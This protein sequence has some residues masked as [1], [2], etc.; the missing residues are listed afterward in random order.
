MPRRNPVYPYRRSAD[1]DSGA[2]QH[3]AV[4][5]V[6]AGPS[7]LTAA[8]E[9]AM[10]GLDVVLLDDNDTVSTGSRAICFAK[11][12]LEI[13]DRL[14]CAAPMLAKGVEWRV[15]KVF[16]RDDQVYQFNLMPDGGHK[17][18]AF[19]NL[20]QYYV[21]EVLIER[22][23][24]LRVDLRWRNRVV[25]VNPRDDRVAVDV[26]TPDGRYRMTCD[27]LLA[28][29][30][31]SSTVGDAIGADAVGQQFDDRFLIADITM[32]AEFPTE[33][34]FWFDPPFHRGQSV[35]LHKQPDG[36]WRV[37]FQLGA[38]ADPDEAVKIENIAPRIDAMLGANVQWDLEWA[39]AYTFRCRKLD[40]F[41]HGRV[42]FV[43]D[44]AHQVSPFGARGANGAVQGI[45]NL[46][47]K[48]VRV[49]RGDASV[50]LLESYDVERQHGAKEN[51]LHS[52]RATDFITPKSTISKVFRNSALR[53]AKDYPFARSLV[54]SG[55][56]SAPC[57]YVDSPLSTPDVDSFTPLAAPGAVCPDA[58]L[59]A[60]DR[61]AWLLEQ[62]GGRF[63]LLATGV[64]VPDAL[65][66][67]V[68]LDVLEI[69]VDLHP[70]DDLLARRYDLERGGAYLIRPDQ[71]VAARWRTLHPLRVLG[72]MRRALARADA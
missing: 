37:D 59:R 57:R 34:W 35:L 56:L 11:R 49:M 18:P 8:I 60:D 27:Y 67:V 63:V 41:V 2:P 23:R 4:I 28:A 44:A 15:G 52:T 24:E 29:D 36:V 10:N 66:G 54:N 38:D 64:P 12:T 19:I 22:A 32:H 62:L 33:R 51:L 42:I 25:G 5:V 6:G 20:Q 21:E 65:R 9:L 39:S 7:G 31:A 55:R 46:V 50:R 69:G 26:E 47:W 3:H 71:H 40:G 68:D 30:G 17:M 43:G 53:L 1:Q 45:E 61:P 16:F 13:W 58:P 72:A 48:L 70:A 14:Q